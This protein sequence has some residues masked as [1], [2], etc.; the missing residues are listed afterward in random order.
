[1][2]RS[3]N[4]NANS[5]TVNVPGN[6][7]PS[8]SCSISWGKRNKHKGGIAKK[9]PNPRTS[10]YLH[11]Q[12]LDI[13][14]TFFHSQ[15]THP[16]FESCFW[17]S[18]PA[19]ED[20][21][22]TGKQTAWTPHSQIVDGRLIALYEEDRK[23]HLTFDIMRYVQSIRETSSAIRFTLRWIPGCAEM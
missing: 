21:S 6:P 12:I 11:N 2:P 14:D 16:T 10:M 15:G 7:F 22:S 8:S 3:I 23:C 19:S 4:T 17:H 9:L 13:T 20:S 18:I 5:G 1:M